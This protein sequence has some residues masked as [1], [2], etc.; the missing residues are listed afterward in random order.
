M[1]VQ[2]NAQNAKFDSE[3]VKGIRQIYNIE[4]AE[5]EKTFQ[6]LISDFPD[7]PAGGFFIAMIDWW[8]ILLDTSTEQRDEI[9]K[10]KVE[11][12]ISHCDKILENDPD[13]VDALFFKGGA[14]GFRGRLSSL[15]QNWLSAADDG[16]EALPLVEQAAESDPENIDVKLGFGIYNYYAEVIPEKYPIVKPLM[17]FLPSGD[18]ELGINQL[19]DIALKGKYTKYEARYFLMSLYYR[20]EK[21]Y[22]AAE[23]YAVMLNEDFPNNPVFER[24][25]GRI[26][27][28]KGNLVSADSIFK[29]ILWKADKKFP[30]YNSLRIK[31]EANYYIAYQYRNT[32]KYDS[33][34]VYFE[35]C[36]NNSLKLDK[37]GESGF[38]INATLYLGMIK[39]LNKEYPAAKMYYEKV[40]DMREYS[41]S[42]SL[43]ENYLERIEKQENTN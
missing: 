9:F 38:L 37:D 12:V 31:R 25:R 20:Y 26:T 6:R 5:A 1:S 4:L 14:I 15:R 23:E 11:N 16:R 30:G 13:N 35:K 19:K 29:N 21:D 39:E 18:K 3:V 41:N 24:W 22:N 43:A 27:I 2:I 7:H 10:E 28:K 33:A 32:A 8:R 40:L 36:I 17:I 42:H 34:Q